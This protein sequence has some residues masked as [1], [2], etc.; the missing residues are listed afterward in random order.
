MD[1]CYFR[2]SGL[3]GS[4]DFHGLG[5]FHQFACPNIINEAIDGDV[6]GYQDM[7]ADAEYVLGDALLLVLG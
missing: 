5:Y 3:Q 4:S 6:L 1:L 7:V 2:S